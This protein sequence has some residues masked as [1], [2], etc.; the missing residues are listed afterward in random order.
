[1]LAYPRHVV[2]MS[3][4]LILVALYGAFNEHNPINNGRGWDGN[5]YITTAADLG[6]G[7]EIVS[8]NPYLFQRML[9]SVV[10]HMGLVATGA[11]KDDP[12]VLIAFA[13]LNTLM[14]LATLAM[15]SALA[16]RFQL[17]L[18]AFWL[19]FL[20]LFVNVQCFKVAG[21]YPALT[22]IP[23][24]ALGMAQVTFYL[25][26]RTLA[27][28]LCTLL[29]VFTWPVAG[30]MGI[31]LILFPRPQTEGEA[32]ED[33]SLA[34][35]SKFARLVGGVAA[36][37]VA[38]LCGYHYLQGIR[39]A[40]W[41]P[42]V[43][44]VES[45]YPISLALTAAYVYLVVSGLLPEPGRLFGSLRRIRLLHLL[46]ALGL[47]ALPRVAVTLYTSGPEWVTIKTFI[48]YVYVLSTTRPGIFLVGH[49]VF[50]GPVLLLLPFVWRRMC[51][52]IGSC[53]LRDHRVDGRCLS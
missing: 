7:W 12:A 21:W 48:P 31:F 40:G 25:T 36:L 50:F 53:L 20:G 23:A 8:K 11:P 22:D 14:M 44:I 13:L 24:L 37:S 29:G 41:G 9:P 15:W 4:L 43:P 51:A 45:L 6:A 42:V 1:M 17:S 32:G 28:A 10:V 47:L 30:P 26:G 3:A 18:A 27:V 39:T 49:L 33:A 46:V 34:A 19:G 52:L 5:E 16:K 38:S 35:P 2:G